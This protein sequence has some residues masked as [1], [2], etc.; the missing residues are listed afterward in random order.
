[1]IAESILYTLIAFMI[2][3]TV[4]LSIVNH[5]VKKASSISRKKKQ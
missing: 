2:H 4:M 1:M 5:E 3:I